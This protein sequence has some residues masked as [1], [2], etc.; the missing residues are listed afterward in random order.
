MSHK[1]IQPCLQVNWRIMHPEDVELL[2]QLR[3]YAD[4]QRISR[5]TAITQAVRMLAAKTKTKK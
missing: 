5:N 1:R 4:E 3:V 2:E